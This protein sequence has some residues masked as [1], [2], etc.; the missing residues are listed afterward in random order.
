MVITKSAGNLGPFW[1]CISSP[2]NAKNVITVGATQSYMPDA[3]EYGY[4]RDP[5]SNPDRVANFSSRGWT[6]DNRIKPDVVAPGEGVLS[7]STPLASGSNLSGLYSEDS[8]Y[9]WCSG[10]S[11]SN[12]AVAGAAAVTVEWYDV[13]HGSRPSPA[14][15]KALLIN[16]A[17]DL[18]DDNG[19]TGPIPNRHEGWGMVDISKLHHPYQ[20]PV[21]F[22]LE[23]QTHVFT[24]SLQTNQHY[25][26]VDRD[27][28]PLKFSLAWTD[29]EAPADTGSA[30]SLINDLNIEVETP[31]GLVYRGNAFSGGWS[32][33]GEDAWSNFDRNG[34]GWDDTNNVEN[35]YIPIDEVE[36][37]TYTVR[38]EARV[39]ADDAVNLG[40]NSQDYALVVYNG[41][42]IEP[43]EVTLI[44]PDGGEVFYANSEEYILWNTSKT[45]DDIDYIEL[46][47]STNGGD[48]WYLIDTFLP[49]TG[50]YLWTVPNI[51]SDQCL[52]RVRAVDVVGKIGEYTSADHFEIVN[53]TPSNPFRINSDSDFAT[54]GLSGDGSEE[55]PYVIQGY[56]INGEGQGYCLYVGNTTAHFV[57]KHNYFYGASGNSAIYFRNN[58]LY[59]FNVA[60]GTVF[61]NTISNNDGNGI[62]LDETKNN[63]LISDNNVQSH[64]YYGIYLRDTS[65]TTIVNN[66]LEDN[67]RGI[68]ILRGHESLISDNTVTG[69]AYGIH[70]AS[71]DDCIVKGNVVSSSTNTGIRLLVSSGITVHHNSIIGNAVQ[72]Y[73]SGTSNWNAPYPYGGNYWDDYE[74]VD[75]K[76]GPGQ[77]IPGPDGIGDTS[78]TDIDGGTDNYPIMVPTEEGYLLRPPIRIN[79]NADF[80]SANGVCSGSG[81]EVDPFIIEGVK[82]NANGPGCGIYVGNTTNHFMV[83]NTYVHDASGK[84][85][86]EYHR[87]TGIYLWNV[88]NGIMVNNTLIDNDSGI[89][90]TGSRNNVIKDNEVT[91]KRT[92][93]ALRAGSYGNRISNNAVSEQSLT[94]IISYDSFENT[95]VKNE[96]WA[97]RDGIYL[98]ASENIDIIDNHIVNNDAVGVYLYGNCNNNTI[99][100]NTI[101]NNE[102]GV[103][104]RE[105][106]LDNII[107]ENQITYNSVQGI[108]LL[109]SSR[110]LVCFND[111]SSNAG[112]GI[113]IRDSSNENV[114]HNNT[115]TGN[116]GTGVDQL[117]S[118]HTMIR[119]N[120]VS[121]NDRGIY[122]HSSN[123]NIVM[124][125]I[126]SSN[127]FDHG[128]YLLACN[129][130]EVVN[131]TVNSNIESGIY[132]RS[133]S[134]NTISSN[135]ADHN[136][137]YGIFLNLSHEN[138]LSNNDIENNEH[139]LYMS[140]S[141]IN[142]IE[143]NTLSNNEHSGIKLLSSDGN[144]IDNN[145]A[146]SNKKNGIHVETS[147]ENILANNSLYSNENGIYIN[148]DNNTLQDNHATG[149]DY[150]IYLAES[151]HNS[152]LR[153][154]LNQNGYGMYLYRSNDNKPIAENIVSDNIK[155]GITI[156]Y[157]ALNTV[158]ENLV[159]ENHYG[160]CIH[161]AESNIIRAN[162]VTNNWDG[163]YVQ[164]GKDN[165]FHGN[166]IRKN[167]NS[168]VYLTASTD[169]ILYH[170][171]FVENKVNAYDDGENKWDLLDPAHGGEGGNYWDDYDGK[172]RG[173]GIG[174][175]PYDHIMGGTN[176]DNYP[177]VRETGWIPVTM[178]LVLSAD[179]NAGGWNFV[180]FNLIPVDNSLES[181][182]EDPEY[183]ISG[184]YDRVMF[185]NASTGTWSSYV[186]GRAAHFNTLDS[187][188]HSMGVWIRMTTNDKLT[189]QGY[190]P[191]RTQI[192]IYPGWNMVGLP[193]SSADNNG[194]P[195]EV[196]RIGFFDAAEE[197][198]VAY[199]YDP[200][201]YTF[202]PGQ[203]YWIYNSADYSVTWTVDC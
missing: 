170:N 68:S 194:L 3:D 195:S 187:W 151:D 146:I 107:E 117:S 74:G 166:M 156:S 152:I 17:H 179:V 66:V 111:I 182:L 78:Y 41:K 125:N 198:N 8:R 83:R 34:D 175:I 172:D 135:K 52:I 129:R 137:M 154:H 160:I 193:S 62:Y 96:I 82:I 110:N 188:D 155:Q 25:V 201:N 4:E 112:T 24:E 123:D 23:D 189:I 22:Y 186:P 87:D 81:S 181:I 174:D 80:I 77:N 106:S 64:I 65:P 57:V 108:F 167:E 10:T 85:G 11:M 138:E 184:N 131:N 113:Y 63:N 118:S 190:M 153:N 88:E 142:S 86:S 148:C 72:A 171:N 124:N 200:E 168:G 47:Y 132:L 79:S 6:A 91:R 73:D 144:L 140:E 46:S 199:D 7:T 134:Y 48:S 55:N 45:G 159:S 162:N 61:D 14:M 141:N 84:L 15:V 197:Y 2:G 98:S 105:N 93:I 145:T 122:L 149:N 163:I 36:Y 150:G 20:N 33:A 104:I 76:R 173:D 26:V 60:N 16:T 126:A 59:L 183:G 128:I 192:T 19:N 12:P 99:H 27:D 114:L 69:N 176:R 158:E 203:G 97:C 164:E 18:D 71:S 121:D 58:G 169:N 89:R 116:Q 120:T 37:G 95:I 39:V 38:V 101:S 130:N 109:G 9:G 119:D 13:N 100:T 50:S 43:P 139:G 42:P 143:M 202:A 40:Y 75:Q 49:D 29:Q 67:A 115:I 53:I 90:I 56:G 31:S 54:L 92:G 32:V 30:P 136:T 161:S 5:V 177:W 133:S 21:P 196:T 103:F 191:T 70:I 44:T 35:V 147:I 165:T 157:S 185:Y 51:E 180:S 178:D 1:T 102:Y 127:S 28:A 94:A